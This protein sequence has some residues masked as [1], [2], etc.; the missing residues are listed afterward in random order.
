MATRLYT[1]ASDLPP[2]TSVAFQSWPDTT[3]AVR[4]NLD[5]SKTPATEV[6]S[7]TLTGVAANQALA[8]QAISPPLDGAQSIA[9]TFS[10]ICHARELDALDNIDQR[11]YYV[12]VIS[13][14]GSTLRGTCK[15]RSTSGTVTE[16]T[17]TLAGVVYSVGNAITTVAALDGDRI[18]IEYGPGESTAGTTPQWEIGLGGNGTDHTT[19]E[20]DTTGTVGWFELSGN[21]LFKPARR[22]RP[23]RA[24]QYR[25]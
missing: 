17:L 22:R 6:R 19:T 24:P 16:Y 7:G 8:V 23:H 25:R 9:G 12:A 2:V 4:R 13:F 1:R 3:Q 11:A 14:D 21:L 10:L 15:V 5:L 18:L 20:G